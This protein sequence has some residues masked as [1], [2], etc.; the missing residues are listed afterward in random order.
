M[1][2]AEFALR[3][4]MLTAAV[5]PLAVSPLDVPL[6]IDPEQVWDGRCYGLLRDRG[7]DGLHKRCAVGGLPR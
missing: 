1:H 7:K 3:H 6:H 2:R 5:A 4:G